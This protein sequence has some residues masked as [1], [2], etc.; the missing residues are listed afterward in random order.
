[1]AEGKVVIAGNSHITCLGVPPFTEDGVPKLVEL[2]IGGTH[3]DAVTG[4]LVRNSAY[5]HFFTRVA[6]GRTALILWQ[7]NQ[8]NATYLFAPS[9]PFDFF[10]AERPDLPISENMEIV[11]ETAVAASF[12][13]SF[14]N[15]HPLLEKLK[16]TGCRPVLCGTPPPKGDN[17]LLRRLL[18]EENH[19]I[20]LAEQMG[21]ELQDVPL[22]SPLLRLK[23]WMVLQR[24]TAEV[25]KS[26]EV[27]FIAVP[28][29]VRTETGFLRQEY[30]ARDAT[31]ANEAYGEVVL[32]HWHDALA[33]DDV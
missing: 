15:L 33:L 11:P 21:V 10:V 22:S 8:H 1:M 30:W 25:G 17:E 3:F 18:P 24:M 9:P 7:G 12:E 6:A 14:A 23:M 13:P 5:W 16:A 32:A 26:H 20:R 2:S 28:E 27:P 19:F 29:R 31:H 4:S